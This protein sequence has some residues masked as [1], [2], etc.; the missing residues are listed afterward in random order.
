MVTP[1]VHRSESADSA[2]CTCFCLTPA[3]DR[4]FHGNRLGWSFSGDHRDDESRLCP[5]SSPCIGGVYCAGNRN[6]CVSN[7][8][9]TAQR[10]MV[11]GVRLPATDYSTAEDRRAEV[12]LP[13]HLSQRA[14][15][16]PEKRFSPGCKKCQIKGEMNFSKPPCRLSPYRSWISG[17]FCQ[18]EDAARNRRATSANA[19]CGILPLIPQRG[20]YL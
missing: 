3:L 2:T 4:R 16:P 17:I 10:T 8:C 1:S 13:H 20:G 11:G 19:S 12:S 9:Y 18:W 5:D 6:H 15:R 14:S 7:P